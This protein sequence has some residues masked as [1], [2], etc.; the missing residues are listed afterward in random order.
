M[1]SFNSTNLPCNIGQKKNGKRQE[2]EPEFVKP[3]NRIPDWW[4]GTTTLFEAADS[5]AP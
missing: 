2:P 1:C 4:A 3:R 5:W